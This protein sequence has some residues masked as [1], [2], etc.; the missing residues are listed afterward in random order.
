MK[1]ILVFIFQIPL[2]LEYTGIIIIGLFFI[3]YFNLASSTLIWHVI[4]LI[5]SILNNSSYALILTLITTSILHNSSYNFILKLKTFKILNNSSYHFILKLLIIIILHNS[6]SPC[7]NCFVPHTILTTF[8]RQVNYLFQQS[9]QIS[10]TI[11]I[12]K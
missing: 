7:F 8:L 5:I 10:I 6:Y 11:I 3:W 12:Q 1:K 2:Y 4:N 9:K